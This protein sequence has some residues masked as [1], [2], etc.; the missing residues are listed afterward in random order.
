MK[1]NINELNLA[2]QEGTYDEVKSLISIINQQVEQLYNG[3]T[4][5]EKTDKVR[6]KNYFVKVLMILYMIAKL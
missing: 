3:I 4:D 6:L 5:I 1:D 2:L